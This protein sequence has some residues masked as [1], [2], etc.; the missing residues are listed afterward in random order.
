MKP[1]P[2]YYTSP[3]SEFC[4]EHL[5]GDFHYLDGD[6]ILLRYPS[7]PIQF[8]RSTRT[9]RICE[10][11]RPGEQLRRSQRE[12]LPLLAEAVRALSSQDGLSDES[13][14]F[15]IEGDSPYELGA[16]VYQVLPTSASRAVGTS[17]TWPAPNEPRRIRDLHA[18]SREARGR[19]T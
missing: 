11:K 2:E 16:S 18:L 3:L 5:P 19:R 9:L 8:A 4:A 17:T 13:G 10:A 12:V 15:I 1:R 14:V 7:Q 6:E